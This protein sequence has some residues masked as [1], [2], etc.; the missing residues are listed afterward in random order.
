MKVNQYFTRLSHQGI[1][2][3]VNLKQLFKCVS[4]RTVAC[5][6]EPIKTLIHKSVYEGKWTYL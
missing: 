4:N 3:G 1:V 6:R 2:A 5:Y